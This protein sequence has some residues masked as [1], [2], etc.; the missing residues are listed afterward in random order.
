MPYQC[1][2]FSVSFYPK[3]IINLEQELNFSMPL[4][5]LFSSE[6]CGQVHNK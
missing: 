2:L 5:N 6:I 3:Y 4:T 1:Y